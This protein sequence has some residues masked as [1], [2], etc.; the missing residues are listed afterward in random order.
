MEPLGHELQDDDFNNFVDQ[1]ISQMKVYCSG[2]SGWV[3]DTLLAVEVEVEAPMRRSGSSFIPTLA[4]LSGLSR[5]ILNDR[6]KSDDLCF[7]YCVFAALYPQKKHCKRP[8]FICICSKD[9]TSIYKIFQCVS[10]NYAF[11]GDEIMF[12]LQFTAP[13]MKIS[14]M[15]ISPKTEQVERRTTNC[16]P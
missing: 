16:C 4:T 8:F 14:T 6:N 2:G 5:S 10:V 7:L 1:L 3:V 11:L 15:F 12:P 9:W 13:R